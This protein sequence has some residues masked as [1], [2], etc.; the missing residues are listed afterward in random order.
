MGRTSTTLRHV[1][2]AALPLAL[3]LSISGCQTA[4]P[5]TPDLEL[6]LRR[7][8]DCDDL[9]ATVTTSL[10]EAIVDGRY[11]NYR[12]GWLAEDGAV[13]A[14]SADD[15]G[16]SGPT[17]YSTTNVQE[18][19]VDELDL[20]KTDWRH[21]FIAS[22]RALQIVKSWPIADTAH[23][24]R[25][26][27][28]G[29]LSGLFLV[30]DVAVVFE[31]DWSDADGRAHTKVH[32]VD[33][34]D[35]TDPTI[36]RTVR[37]DGWLTDARLV[38]GDVYAVLNQWMDIPYEIWEIGW[39]D[40]LGLPEID[41]DAPE[42]EREAAKAQMRQL[43]APRVAAAVADLSAS[44][45][46]PSWDD[47]LGG[48][49]TP[50]LG[51]SDIYAPGSATHLSMMSVVRLDPADGSTGST[52]LL[53]DGWNIY[54]STNNLY[55]A[56]SSWW[57]WGF[58]E[59]GVSHIHQFSLHGD[60][61]PIYEGSGS[62]EGWLYDQFAMSEHNGYLRVVSTD[63]RWWGMETEAEAPANHV[64]VL[65]NQS[66]SLVR[67]GHV[68]GI[69]PNEQI[70]AA[71]LMGDKGYMVTFETTDPL[72]TLDLSDPVAPR[73]VGELHMP[74]FSA[75]LHPVGADHLLAVGMDGLD[76][77]TL[78]GLAITMFDVSD[79]ANPEIESQ[80]ALNP[81]TGNGWSWSWS[82]A[83]WDH[84]A[85][86]YHRDVLTIPA[87]FEQ[88]DPATER[89]DGFSGTV[90]F[91][92]RAGHDIAEIGRVDHHDLVSQSQCIYDIWYDWDWDACAWGSYWYAKVR[93]S[94]VI[95]DNLFT[96]SDYGV[97]VTD[98]L[99]PTVE[100]AR[101]VYYPTP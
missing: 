36:D 27:F 60:G 52:G 59:E 96:I 14:P 7:M 21:L 65:Q 83:M 31:Q 17:D 44:D 47:G 43:I 94:V 33:V 30:D 70:R 4:P 69:A 48:G 78:T 38:E 101:V 25:L 84:H 6:T 42:Y 15:G 49:S 2:S 85:F 92:A 79:F 20:V 98:L 29:W 67:V 5:V 81:P 8:V 24:G 11:G 41:W 53:G 64:S 90:S 50:L 10:V 19:G 28:R 32:F 23:V 57:W 45:L 80:L 62:V 66:G 75:Y 34:S 12:G 76:D 93:R 3:A 72:F 56:Q 37:Y 68:G 77:G 35:P 74:G 39:D 1:G 22:D 9:E 61:D 73:V 87:F 46:L 26:T 99:D 18:A 97:K 51:C 88:Y 91:D 55:V 63:F 89:W 95:E 16:G 54:A 86:T 40:T 71:R 82:E 100:H 13:D 58:E